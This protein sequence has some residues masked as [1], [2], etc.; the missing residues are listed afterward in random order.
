[1]ALLAKEPRKEWMEPLATCLWTEP[2]MNVA[3]AAA[4]AIDVSCCYEDCVLALV[5]CA[6]QNPRGYF[7]AVERARL[8]I[9][10]QSSMARFVIV[11]FF[12][13]GFPQPHSLFP[14]SG[15]Y[16]W[17]L[18][19][20]PMLRLGNG[21]PSRFCSL[22]PS[23]PIPF[24]FRRLPKRR[25][26]FYLGDWKAFERK[27]RHPTGAACRLII[28]LCASKQLP[29]WIGKKALFTFLFVWPIFQ[30]D[31]CLPSHCVLCAQHQRPWLKTFRSRLHRW[32]PVNCAFSKVRSD[33]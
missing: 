28:R 27:T 20:S 3:S 15:S 11:V 32:A 7:L 31:P 19:P 33:G 14:V 29:F 24:V 21:C 9:P 6:K 4:E 12:W 8:L 13:G 16:P 22:V 25:L 17:P 18:A 23:L 5:E 26:H 30:I 10:S 1:M 2:D